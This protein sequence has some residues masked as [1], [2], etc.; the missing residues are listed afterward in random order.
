MA[1]W[2]LCD[3]VIIVRPLIVVT[4]SDLG[5]PLSQF[6]LLL[7][8]VGE[9]CLQ[10]VQLTFDLPL[11]VLHVLFGRGQGAHLHRQLRRLLLQGLLGL[12]QVRLHL[13]YTERK[14]IQPVNGNTI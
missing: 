11:L 12:V 2:A 4:H 13:G 14:G 6:A 9:A 5:A 8:A 10:L 3:D 7:L 1:I